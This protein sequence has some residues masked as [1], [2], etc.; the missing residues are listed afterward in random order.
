AKPLPPTQYIPDHDFDTR[1]IA[2]DLKFDWDKEQLLGIETITF[3]PLVPNLNTVSLDA[4]NITV[5]SVKLAAGTPLKFATESDQEKVTISLDHPYQP[6][7]ELKLI[8]DYH[9]NGPQ[10][11]NL[12][13][14]TGVGLRFIKPNPEDPS[15]PKQIWSQGE[16]EYNRYWFLCYD[17]P[18][19]FFTS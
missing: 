13:G 10:N 12:S 7:D 15:R 14:L 6:T 19:D 4:V 2:L 1:H 17:H 5:A 18:N 16:S 9:T 8:I 3:A 11:P